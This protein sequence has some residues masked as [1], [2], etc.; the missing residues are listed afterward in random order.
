MKKSLAILL[1]ILSANTLLAQKENDSVYQKKNIVKLNLF[2][3]GLK[4]ISIQYERIVSRKVSVG[5]GIRYMPDGSL[6]FK[7]TFKNLIDDEDTKN[8]VDNITLGNFAITPEVRFYTGK[9]GAPRGFY[10]APFVRIARYT[11]KLP[12]TYD[13]AGTKKSIDLSGSLSTVTGGI[14]FGKQWKLGKQIY[15]DWWLFGPQYGSSNGKIDGKKTLTPSE[16]TSLRQELDDLDVPL[17]KITYTVDGNG[18]VVNFKGPWAGV[19][20][21][22]C[23]GI[24]F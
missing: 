12:F 3:L 17:T 14:L 19:R 24:N 13:D 11:T 18:A 22:L 5:L 6:P 4:N 15:L 7:T 9:K 1:L 8:Q 10:I 2:A 16:Q 20:S 23:L 21:G